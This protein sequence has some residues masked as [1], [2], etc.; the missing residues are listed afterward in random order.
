MG[1]HC[2][3]RTPCGKAFASLNT[4][5][6]IPSASYPSIFTVLTPPHPFR[7]PVSKAWFT[8]WHYMEDGKWKRAYDQMPFYAFGVQQVTYPELKRKYQ[9][10][11]PPNGL[12][13]VP[14]M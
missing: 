4:I 8:Y 10:A 14:L 3:T 7:H 11:A 2:F 1:M 12:P 13:H 6:P 5:R 9:E